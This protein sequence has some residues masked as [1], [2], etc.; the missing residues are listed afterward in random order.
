M[1]SGKRKNIDGYSI[2]YRDIGKGK[3]LFCIPS[4]PFSSTLFI[5]LAE[6][7]KKSI[8][9]IALDLP[10]FAGRSERPNEVLSFDKYSEIIAEFIKSFDFEE[11][12][13]L[14]YSF[15]G[16]AAQAIIN[17][18]EVQPQKTVLVSSIYRGNAIKEEPEFKTA[19]D[20]FNNLPKNKENPLFKLYFYY[21]II[22]LREEDRT[23]P[24]NYQYKPG[25]Q[26][27]MLQEILNC[28]I[29]SIGNIWNTLSDREFI[30]DNIQNTQLLAIYADHD[31]DFVK[32]DMKKVAEHVGVKPV[33]IPQ[34]YHNHLF[35][36]PEKSVRFIRDFLLKN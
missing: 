25:L 19:I 34:A 35:Y 4:W 11:Y 7:I 5:P 15:G 32:K 27:S 10:G 23:S 26:L 16:I 24:K 18:G 9:A 8:R 36:E 30:G 14:G 3:P 22:N 2:H 33:K 21:R 20:E 28:N 17:T 29:D 13:L 6:Y 1:S 12:S 31:M